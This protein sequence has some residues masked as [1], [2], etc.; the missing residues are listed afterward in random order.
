MTLA[1]T[2]FLRR[3]FLHVLPRGFVRIRHFGFLA[4]RFRVSRL[5]LCRQLLACG[6]SMAQAVRAEE[7]HSES[8]S[9]WHCPRC[10]ASMLVVQRFTSC[11]TI[12][13][14]VLRFFLAAPSAND[15]G[16]CASTPTHS[17]LD[18]VAIAPLPTFPF[19][20]FAARPMITSEP[21]HFHACSADPRNP[22]S[23]RP[24]KSHRPASAAPAASS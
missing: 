4:N 15:S 17:C 8:S 16:M 1:G 20:P 23:R 9:L 10:G 21:S 12:N 7:V 14:H 13:M 22:T 5:A 18:L 3:F 2:E 11:G 19:H 24:F 6:A